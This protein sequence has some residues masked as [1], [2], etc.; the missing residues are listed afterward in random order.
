MLVQEAQ[1]MKRKLSNK[2]CEE[3]DALNLFDNLFDI[4]LSN[5]ID[6]IKKDNVRDKEAK[7][8]DISFLK[9]QR[10]NRTQFI[11]GSADQR[12]RFK[13]NE[14]AKKVEQRLK[15]VSM[16]RE[17]S[18]VEKN[19]TANLL[20]NT[21]SECEMDRYIEDN[22]KVIA[23]KNENDPDYTARIND[24]ENAV[25]NFNINDMLKKTSIVIQRYNVGVGARRWS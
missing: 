5:A 17:R 6:K 24:D 7:Q 1:K 13:A 9:D 16:L 25:L 21:L 11:G 23:D 22:N 15:E 8:A 10:K 3:K 12:F 19:K 20:E 18:E 4:S 14:Q 2:S